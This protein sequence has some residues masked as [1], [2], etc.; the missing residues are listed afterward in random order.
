MQR[1]RVGSFGVVFGCISI[2][3]RD[4]TEFALTVDY[5]V[6]VFHPISHIFS[7]ISTIKTRNLCCLF[8]V[9]SVHSLTNLGI[10]VLEV[11]KKASCKKLGHPQKICILSSPYFNSSLPLVFGSGVIKRAFLSLPLTTAQSAVYEVYTLRAE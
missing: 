9:T 11:D 7:G 5:L 10:H 3:V 8:D 6:F 1:T 4:T 2:G